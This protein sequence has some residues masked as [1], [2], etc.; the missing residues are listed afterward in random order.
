[1]CKPA[2]SQLVFPNSQTFLAHTL[3]TQAGKLRVGDPF[4][5][6][7]EWGRVRALWSGAGEALQEVGPGRHAQVG[8]ASLMTSTEKA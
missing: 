7:T 1:M 2:V 8:V 4:V 3:L 6:G 5:V